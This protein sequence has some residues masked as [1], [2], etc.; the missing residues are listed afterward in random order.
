MR[1]V[2]IALIL[3][4]ASFFAQAQFPDDIA[5]SLHQKPKLFF[6]FTGYTSYIKE[7]WATF[8]GIRAGL[9]F[10]NTVKFGLGVSHLN[11][12]VVTPIHITEDKMNYSVNASLHFTYAEAS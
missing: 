6:N 12:S 8:S 10:N 1:S 7:D 5:T 11:S 9:N 4:I 3:F 2:G